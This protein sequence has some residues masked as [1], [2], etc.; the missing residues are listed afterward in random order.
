MCD[1]FFYPE[2]QKFETSFLNFVYMQNTCAED[3]SKYFLKGIK[4]LMAKKYFR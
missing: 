3:I 2:S 1:K 4:P